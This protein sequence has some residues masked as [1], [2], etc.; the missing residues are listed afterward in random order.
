M[1]EASMPGPRRQLSAILFADVH[2]YSRL[3]AK[4]EERELDAPSSA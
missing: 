1:P 3:M 4:N 2:G